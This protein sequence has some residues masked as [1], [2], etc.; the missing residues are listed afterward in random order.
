MT[1]AI[2]SAATSVASVGFNRIALTFLES[3][4]DASP[5]SG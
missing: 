3:P 4:A 1:V 2:V 5:G